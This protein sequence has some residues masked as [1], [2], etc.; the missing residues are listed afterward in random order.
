MND[1]YFQATHI[2]DACCL[3]NLYASRRIA[4]ILETLKTPVAVAD[5]VLHKEALWVYG[6]PDDNV[7]ASK[8]IIDLKN[9]QERGLLIITSLCSE[10]EEA[11]MVNYAY[12]IKDEG[13]AI[14]GAIAIHRNWIMVTDDGR[15]TNYLTSQIPTLKIVST[16]D[17]VK[18]WV[19]AST[20][21]FLEIQSVLWNIRERAKYKPKE[22]HPLYDWW[23]NY[24]QK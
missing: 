21:E 16:L 22:G 3:I 8:E 18:A 13:D 4:D 24:M 15:A 17:L 14:T 2:L 11:T 1:S 20:L 9:L 19:D 5:Y 10:L 7:R 12:Y 6:G 23:R